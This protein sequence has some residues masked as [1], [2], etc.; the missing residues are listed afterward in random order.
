VTLEKVLDVAIEHTGFHQLRWSKR[1]FSM[2]LL[3][4]GKRESLK[5]TS[6]RTC[7]GDAEGWTHLVAN[8]TRVSAGGSHDEKGIRRHTLGVEGHQPIHEECGFAASRSTQDQSTLR[9]R[10]SKEWVG[11]GCH[12]LEANPHS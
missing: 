1:V 11:V 3:Q 7:G 2:M 8:S 9:G 6:P 10:C 4:D 12:P 5:R